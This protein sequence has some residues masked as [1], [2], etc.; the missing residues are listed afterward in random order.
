MNAIRFPGPFDIETGK[1]VE[2][3]P[4]LLTIEAD[5]SPDMPWQSWDGLAPLAWYGLGHGRWEGPHLE[6]EG[7]DSI[8]AP[9][10]GVSATWAARHRAAIWGALEMTRTAWES[11]EEEIARDAREDRAPRG[12][13][14]LDRMAERLEEMAQG[15]KSDYLDAVAALW[16]LRGVSALAFQRNGYSQGDSVLG[17]L[18]QT[19]AFLKRVGLESP[20]RRTPEEIKADL[21]A[22]ADLLGA[23]A[24]G[25]VFRYVLETPDGAH[26]DSCW[27]FYGAYWSEGGKYLLEAAQERLAGLAP[28]HAAQAAQAA[29]E[30]RQAFLEARREARNAQADGQAR[31]TLCALLARHLGGLADTWREKKAEARAWRDLA[32]ALSSN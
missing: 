18:V 14:R 31:P 23:W 22:E 1:A 7:P 20:D 12:Q 30:A 9:L 5:D 26:L 10:D 28:D 15:S 19:P 3:G 8:L 21:E 25:D 2:I 13:V 29:Q 17:L 32:A 6:A 11:L 16:R 27:G 24:F 4:A